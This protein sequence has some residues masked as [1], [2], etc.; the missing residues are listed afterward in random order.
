[1]YIDDLLLTDNN[2]VEVLCIKQELM[3]QFGM[4]NKREVQTYL[5]TKIVRT[6]VGIWMH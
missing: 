3:M 2:K 1:M 6:K 4:F 5:G